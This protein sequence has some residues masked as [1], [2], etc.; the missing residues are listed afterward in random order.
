M[1]GEEVRWMEKRRGR[2]GRGKVDGEEAR[3]MGKR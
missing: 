1:D 2:W 3:W